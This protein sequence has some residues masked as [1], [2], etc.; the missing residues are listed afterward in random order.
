MD[1]MIA[2]RS[3]KAQGLKAKPIYGSKPLR[4]TRARDKMTQ[5]M[6]N[7]L[8]HLVPHRGD[9]ASSSFLFES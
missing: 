9:L 3:A 5:R 7:I 6:A 2:I 4:A 8:V 1:P